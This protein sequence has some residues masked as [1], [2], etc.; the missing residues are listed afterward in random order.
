MTSMSANKPMN[1]IVDV[2][3]GS[4][5]TLN[6]GWE[7]VVGRE[8]GEVFVVWICEEDVDV[9]LQAWIC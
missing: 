4:F 3:E 1:T 9:L 2:F 5:G 7:E 6:C 8:G